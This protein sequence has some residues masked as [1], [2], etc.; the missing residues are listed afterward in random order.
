MVTPPPPGSC[1]AVCARFSKSWRTSLPKPAIS[2]RAAAQNLQPK[3]AP[4]FGAMPT[5]RHG[6]LNERS[7]RTQSG[8]NVR[9]A[10]RI[11]PLPRQTATASDAGRVRQPGLG[12]INAWQLRL[13]PRQVRQPR[14]HSLNLIVI[15]KTLRVP[16]RLLQPETP[17]GEFAILA[18]KPIT[19]LARFEQHLL[20][21]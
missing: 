11:R 3:P 18:P 5:K 4:P 12:V 9:P 2:S 8:V 13:L 1:Q 7:K 6:R 10:H 16:K 15:L 19:F 21:L 17:V 14:S 20:S